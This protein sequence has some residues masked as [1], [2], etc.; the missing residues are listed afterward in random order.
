M[1]HN[2]V[3]L[4]YSR[5]R[6]IEIR[7][8]ARDPAGIGVVGPPLS[9]LVS[10]RRIDC[11]QEARCALNSLLPEQRRPR[12]QVDEVDLVAGV[13]LDFLLRL[14]SGLVHERAVRRL[15]LNVEL[16]AGCLQRKLSRALLLIP[17][18]DSRA[19]SSPLSLLY[20]LL[21]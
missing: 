6:E 8:R 7:K 19:L 18:S 11:T 3:S 5:R 14:D 4:S 10:R 20:L 12:A 13:E 1:L 2:F 9:A 17:V 16:S 21:S 15:V